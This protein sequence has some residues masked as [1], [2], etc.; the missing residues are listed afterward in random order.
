[1]SM[2]IGPSKRILSSPHY[3]WWAYGA[4]AI[5]LFVT[6]MDQSGVNIA[7]PRIADHFSADLPTV[8]WIMLGYVLSTSVMVMPLGRLSDMIGRKWVY[9]GGFLVFMGAAALGGSAQTFMVLIVAKII[10]GI[11]T[12][13]IQANGIAMV[14]DVF[15]ERERGKALGFYMTIIG[16]GSISGPIVGGL[17]VSGLGWR[18]V[19]FA[20]I[21]V[22]VLALLAAMAVLR[23]G[24]PGRS[25]GSGRP[26]FDWVG[27]SLSSAM[28]ISFL[29]AM[30]NAHRLGW[31]SP[32]IVAGFALAFL[33]LLGFVWWELRTEDPMLDLNFFRSR[34]F[35]LGVSARFLQFVGGT[36]VFFLMP[37]YLIQALGYPASRAG[38][39]MVPGSICM[40][41]MGPIGGLV[42]DKVGTRWPSVLGM[43]L[44]A[45]AM[46][47][48][49]RLTV[50]SSPAHVIIG[51]VLAGSGMGAFSS[52]NSSAILSSLSKE[53]HGIVSAFLNLTRTSANLTGIALVTTIV[54]VTMGSLGFEAS[55][56]AV[57]DGDSAGARAAFVAGMNKAFLTAGSLV[58][59]AAVLSAL[60]GEARPVQTPAAG[61]ARRPQPSPT[62]TPED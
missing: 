11:G 54:T 21:P 28:L 7:L 25:G 5:G 53:K 43:G 10:Q 35:S 30:T 41:I 55:L 58:T 16:T 45:S 51:M 19:F 37:F 50:D 20:G 49:A 17:L 61:S 13:G 31:G 9:I 3:K 39:L 27:A 36:S 34:V 4:I 59:L 48:F 57:S 8:Q 22:G 60:R 29:L 46:F 42:S 14:A 12:A 1:M 47:I 52:S 40:A 24:V 26:R 15:P 6:V 62:A 32:P 56:A 2:P 23:G 38:L 18:S 33:L 44:T